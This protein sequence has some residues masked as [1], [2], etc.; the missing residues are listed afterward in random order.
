MEVGY[1][2]GCIQ[3]G[4][5]LD[6]L[7]T[8]YEWGVGHKLLLI[9]LEIFKYWSYH[10]FYS[11]NPIFISLLGYV[12]FNNDLFTWLQL[13]YL[14]LHFQLQLEYIFFIPY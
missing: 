1:Y 4:N 14:H 9:E 3:T 10:L 6:T 5:F 11:V 12:Y 13:E 7:P 8:R 2:K